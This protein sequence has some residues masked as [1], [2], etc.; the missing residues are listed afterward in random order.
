MEN[1]NNGFPFYILPSIIGFIIAEIIVYTGGG[2]MSGN[3]IG[4]IVAV[5]AVAGN[6]LALYFQFKKDS[7]KIGEVKADT[8]G[9]K[10]R[11]SN[12]DENVKKV[13]DEVVE[14]LVPGLSNTTKSSDKLLIDVGKLVTELEF[15]KRLK[16]ELS[17]ALT[18][19]DYL[20]EGIN[21]IYEDNASLNQTIKEKDKRIRE[22]SRENREIIN[23]LEMA[24][25][26][27]RE[28][29][30]SQGFER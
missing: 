3:V 10:P 22:L 17:G 11:V 13:R 15:Q 18:T 26:R 21:S 6:L 7:N 9:M 19:P 20:L 1:K 5:I 8:S 4:I 24:Q 23:R 28:L 25:K 29:E 14:R 27:V 12:I 2:S 16:S 30:P